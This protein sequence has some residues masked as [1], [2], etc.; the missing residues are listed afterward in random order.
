VEGLLD[1]GDEAVWVFRREPRI[2]RPLNEV[3]HRTPQGLPYLAPE[4]QLLYKARNPRPRDEEDFENVIPHLDATARKWLCESL[5]MTQPA[6]G[7]LPSLSHA[8]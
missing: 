6:H 2:Q 7:W 4:I 3:I 5:Q 8:L 1:A